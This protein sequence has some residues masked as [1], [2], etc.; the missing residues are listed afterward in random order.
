MTKILRS[1]RRGEACEVRYPE[2]SKQAFSIYDY[3]LP[4]RQAYR[5]PLLDGAAPSIQEA[6]ELLEAYKFARTEVQDIKL[7]NCIM[8]ALLDWTEHAFESEEALVAKLIVQWAIKEYSPTRGKKVFPEIQKF[9][10]HTAANLN[11]STL[12]FNHRS[13]IAKGV[14]WQDFGVFK[15]DFK[16]KGSQV[17]ERIKYKGG[18]KVCLADTCELHAYKATMSCWKENA[19]L[20]SNIWPQG[21]QTVITID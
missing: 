15:I 19:T 13:A 18:Q 21:W 5:R 4:Y 6:N 3:W 17:S 9:I 14:F 16:Y 7:A 12:L 20:E 11:D 1:I 10:L 8:D 2:Y